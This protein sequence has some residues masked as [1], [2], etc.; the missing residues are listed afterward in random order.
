ME[1]CPDTLVMTG[2]AARRIGIANH[3]VMRLAD[4]G[5]LPIFARTAEGFF[6]FRLG[7]VD[8]ARRYVDAN[9][10]KKGRKPVRLPDPDKGPA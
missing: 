9:P 5:V 1:Y 8:A 4:R 3:G 7:D 10:P 6:L 2:T